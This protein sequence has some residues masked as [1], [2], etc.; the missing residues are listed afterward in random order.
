MHGLLPRTA[1]I[2]KMA[3]F[4]RNCGGLPA[5]AGQGPGSCMEQPGEGGAHYRSPIGRYGIGSTTL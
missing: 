1:A 2:D 5:R 4:L 3:A